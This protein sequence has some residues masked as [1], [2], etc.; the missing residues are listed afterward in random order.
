M[1]GRA[2]CEECATC[3]CMEGLVCNPASRHCAQALPEGALCSRE[4]GVERGAGCAWC[5]GGLTCSDKGVCVRRSEKCGH[6][7]RDWDCQGGMVCKML[8][9]DASRGKCAMAMGE[10]GRCH[11]SCWGC[12]KG[13]MCVRG[14]CRRKGRYM[15]L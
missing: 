9:E 8:R 12:R 4:G 1:K 3:G 5:A 6:C 14:V 13:L 15:Y 7:R 2:L 10:G 11:D